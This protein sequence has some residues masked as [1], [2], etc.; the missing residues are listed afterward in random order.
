MKSIVAFILAGG[1]M[2][3]YGVLTQNRAK[4]ALTIAGVYRL[5]DFA[6]SNLVNSGIV[7]IGLIIQY[8]PGSLIEH[9]G[10]GHPWDLDNY[11]K[12]LKIM[13]PFVG[14][15]ETAWYNG[16]ADAIRRNLGFA[17]DQDAK[18]VVVLSG[19]HLFHCDFRDVIRQHIET[20]ADMTVITDQLPPEHCSQRFGYV[21][22]EDDGRISSYIEKPT[23]P[24][25]DIAATGIYVFKTSVLNDLL[26][27]KDH[28]VESN[29]ARDIIQPNIVNISAYEYRL[30]DRWEYMETARDY[31]DAQF[32]L[33]D[34]DNFAVLRKWDIMTNLKFRNV[35]HAPAALFGKESHVEASMIGPRCDIQGTVINSILSPGVKVAAGATV[36]NSIIMHDCTIES[37]AR[38]DRVISDRDAL[39]SAG[40]QVGIATDDDRDLADQPLTL[41]GKGAI[42]KNDQVVEPGTQVQ[43]LVK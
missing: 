4:G 14:M 42:I 7:N 9:V 27:N 32:R 28:A 18:N 24:P 12:T 2:G 33:K 31:Y 20:D 23:T 6:L 11:G 41:I 40:S 26:Q 17:R 34:E 1:K 22:V 37:G 36:A 29:L 5:I 30:N 3:D 15:Q 43:P 38:L 21:M 8:L 16:N 35:G 13:P 19:E 39:F 25:S 10:S